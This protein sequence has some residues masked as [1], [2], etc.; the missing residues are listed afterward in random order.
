M[1]E[2]VTGNA[3]LLLGLMSGLLMKHNADE[4]DLGYRIVEVDARAGAV[5]I[6]SASENL[7]RLSIVQT[8]GIE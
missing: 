5:V 3:Q 6:Q 7:F 4:E 2:K 1:I 8:A